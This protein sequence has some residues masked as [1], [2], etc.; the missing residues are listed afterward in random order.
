MT[1]LYLMKR[2]WRTYLQCRIGI[3]SSLQRKANK[4]KADC[5]WELAVDDDL[6]IRLMEATY[7]PHYGIPQTLWESVDNSMTQMYLDKI[8]DY[9]ANNWPRGE[10]L[11][12]VM[13]HSKDKPTWIKNEENRKNRRQL[14]R[15]LSRYCEFA[16][17]KQ[18]N[19]CQM[20]RF[21]KGGLPLPVSESNL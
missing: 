8:W 4:E 7:S 21:C 20:P 6:T 16:V 11:L 19:A 12:L 5:A 13:G 2:R 1:V 18:T 10:Q 3:T 9:H 14:L 17:C 15:T